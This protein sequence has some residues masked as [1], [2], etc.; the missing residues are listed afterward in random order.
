MLKAGGRVV[1]GDYV[2]THAYAAAFA[3]AGLTVLQSRT[4]FGVALSLM[5]IVIA[6][7]PFDARP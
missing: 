7:K 4:A 1:V 3:D 5:W 2:P 6:E